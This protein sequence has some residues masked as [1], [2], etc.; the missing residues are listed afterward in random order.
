[1][2]IPSNPKISTGKT[3]AP[4]DKTAPVSDVLTMLR[5]L[6]ADCQKV[7][8]GDDPKGEKLRSYIYKLLPILDREIQRLSREIAKTGRPE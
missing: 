4:V 1:M 6:L 8:L 7:I 5:Y 2:T 3:D